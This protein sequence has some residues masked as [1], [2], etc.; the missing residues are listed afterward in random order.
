MKKIILLIFVFCFS[1]LIV[2]ELKIK[3]DNVVFDDSNTAGYSVISSSSANLSENSFHY[4]EKAET[5]RNNVKYQ[6]QVNVLTQKCNEDAKI[7]TWAVQKID[8]SGFIRLNV[9]AIA[10]DYE[11]NHPGWKVIGGINADQYYPKF[12]VQ[13][14]VDGSDYFYPQPYGCLIA[15]GEKWFSINAKPYGGNGTYLAGFLN[16]GSMD[17][18]IEGRTNWTITDDSRF[19]VSGLYVSVLNEYNEVVSKYKIDKFNEEPAENE[20]SLFSPYYQGTTMP[21]LNVNF[22]NLIV[23]EDSDLSYVSNSLTYTYKADYDAKNINNAQN[24]FFGK[25]IISKITTSTNL[26]SGQFA[27]ATNNPQLLEN[28]QVGKKIIVQYEYEGKINEV[29]S[30]TAYHTIMRMDGK[31]KTSNNSYNTKQ[32]PRAFFGRKDDGTMVLITVD[33]SQ[34]SKGMVGTNQLEGCALLKYYGV[35]EAYQMDGGGSVTMVV[36]DNDNFTVVNSPSDGSPRSVLSALLFVVR[37][38][39]IDVYQTSSTTTSIT[40]YTNIVKTFDKPIESLYVKIN[41]KLYSIKDS[42]TIITGLEPNTEY[43]YQ[44]YTKDSKQVLQTDYIGHVKTQSLPPVLVNCVIENNESET[45]INF[46]F[47]NKDSIKDII[48]VINDK[49]Y[50]LINGQFVIDDFQEKDNIM[51]IYSYQTSFYED[52][53]IVE[54]NNPIYLTTIT[55]ENYYIEINGSISS[56]FR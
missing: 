41:S 27:I 3:A 11:K 10:Q 8:G 21:T 24:A 48:L 35:T 16:D 19:Y 40:L 32:Y 37:D 28:L 39:K 36:R 9:G 25:G 45:Y 26:N 44:L 50:D 49:S 53:V 54:F 43:T 13:G 17:Q 6:Q 23:V 2:N 15:D 46:E 31:D 38:V 52:E 30:A 4:L 51:L 1:F 56:I 5:I 42:Y 34:T 33:G 29:E 20:S 18:I 22:N 12:G 14:H 47:D 55:L 7:V